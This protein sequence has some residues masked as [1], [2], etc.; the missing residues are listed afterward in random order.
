MT[1]ISAVA[2]QKGGVAQPTTDV[3]LALVGVAQPIASLQTVRAPGHALAVIAARPG[4]AWE[5]R[6]DDQPA[7]ISYKYLTRRVL[8]G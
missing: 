8:H 4:C 2:N 3:T 7:T 6:P 5:Y 1:R